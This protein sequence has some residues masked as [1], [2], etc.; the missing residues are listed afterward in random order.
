MRHLLGI[1][2]SAGLLFS[3]P[4]LSQTPAF[5]TGDEVLATCSSREPTD[6]SRCFAFL[7][8]VL[9]GITAMVWQGSPWPNICVPANAT[10]GQLRD[11]IVSQLQDLREIRHQPSGNLILT[12]LQ[13]VYPCTPNAQSSEPRGK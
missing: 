8:G 2:A 9:R 7:T 5:Q 3:A 4:A 1:V 11:L 13:N 6:Q 12:I 10:T